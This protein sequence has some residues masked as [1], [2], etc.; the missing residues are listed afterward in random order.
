MHTL[1]WIRFWPHEHM[2]CRGPDLFILTLDLHEQE[3]CSE[4]NYFYIVLL[5]IRNSFVKFYQNMVKEKNILMST[6]HDKPLTK[7]DQGY[8][9]VPKWDKFKLNIL[10]NNLSNG[11]KTPLW[12]PLIF[13]ECTCSANAART[14][15]T[16]KAK[17]TKKHL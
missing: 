13:N 6:V 8:H 15:W 10:M 12:Q 1:S 7:K 5:L 11:S 16:W 4:H 14:P 9:L 2:F 17:R 3:F